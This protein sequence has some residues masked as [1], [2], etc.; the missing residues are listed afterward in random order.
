MT[1]PVY[2]KINRIYNRTQKKRRF[3]NL[4]IYMFDMYILKN[5]CPWSIRPT[6]IIRSVSRDLRSHFNK[7]VRVRVRVEADGRRGVH[8]TRCVEIL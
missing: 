4:K 3:S 6:D 2:N 8:Y 7:R 5:L 1:N